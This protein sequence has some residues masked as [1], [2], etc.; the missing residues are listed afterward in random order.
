VA[1]NGLSIGIPAGQCFGLLGINGAGKTTT[2]G[3]LT[4]EFPPTSGD[5]TLASY[6]VTNNPEETR[7]RIGYCPQFRA[8]FMNLTGLEHVEMYAAIKGIPREFITE[9]ARCKLAEV[10]LSESDSNRLS[11]Q[12]SGGMKRKLS[13]ACATIGN[14]E[15]VFLDEP[16]TGMDPV[17]RRE[18]WKVISAMVV[19]DINSNYTCSVILTTHSMEECEALCPRIAIMAEGNLKC[20]GSA[21]HLKNR[22]GQGYQ[23]ELKVAEPSHDDDDLKQIVGVL[24]ELKGDEVVLDPENGAG[25]N[26]IFFNLEQAISAARKV[27]GDDHISDKIN[28][29]DPS[30]Y[31]IFKNANSEVGVELEVLAAFFATTLRM[32]RLTTFFAEKY[33]T[34]VIRE[35]QDTRIRFEVPSAGIKVGS[36]FSSIEENKEDLN[37]QDYGISQTTLEQ[38][39]NMHAAVAEAKKQGADDG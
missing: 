28:E 4:A 15:I 7:K 10:G 3:I 16:S 25:R 39:F 33:K 31:L 17:S 20:I 24:L 18:L 9:A 19:G 23:V 32:K 26:E 38:V 13:V 6:S 29:H 36:L 21:Q 2:M 34:S 12:Y 27:A 11:S 8:H 22:F 1:V 37:L 35:V 14:P 30:G 5:A